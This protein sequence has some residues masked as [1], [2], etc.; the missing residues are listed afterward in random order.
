MTVAELMDEY[1]AIAEWD[2]STQQTNEGFIRR[3]IKPALR[4]LRVREVRG[5]VLD[6]LYARLKR[7]GDVAC[8]GSAF[9]EHRRMRALSVDPARL[10]LSLAAGPCRPG[11]RDTVRGARSRRRAR[12]HH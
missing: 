11:R 6:K 12:L 10:A 7:S 9:I 8:S 1:G 3:T 5:P 4:H 2:V